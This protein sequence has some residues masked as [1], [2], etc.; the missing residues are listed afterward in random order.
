MNGRRSFA[1]LVVRAWLDLARCD[2]LTALCGFGYIRARLAKQPTRRVTPPADAE[3]LICEAVL[4]ATCFYWK[5]V[6]CLQGSVAVTRLL[7]AHG[8]PARMVIG[9]REAPFFSHAWVEVGSRVVN[10]S[11]VYRLRLRILHSI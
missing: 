2:L 8:V 9:Y 1:W 5:P 6:L 3:T 10:D 4:L 7:R 11:P